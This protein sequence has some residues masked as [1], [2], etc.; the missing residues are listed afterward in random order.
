MAEDAFENLEKNKTSVGGG[1][2]YA[3]WWNTEN[4]NVEDG[5]QLIGIVV[6]KHAYTDPGGD[7]HPVG[8]VRSVGRGSLDAGTE[9]STPTRTSVEPFVE[10]TEVGD[11]VF[12]EYGGQV[13]ANSGR[14]MH[15]YEA[16]KMPQS[17]WEQTNQ[18]DEILEVW[19]ASPHFSGEFETN[20]SDDSDDMSEAQNFAV[21]VLKM[22]GGE[23][24]REEFD[25]Y[26]NDIKDYDVDTDVL[27][28]ETDGVETDGDDVVKN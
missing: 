2:D 23:I 26:V 9:A 5:D 24:S 22:N 13:K 20:V 7:D 8:T 15:I 4:F 28:E 21:D 27:I 10:D 17:E 6:E 25:E 1:S 11:L 18:A 3:P 19:E 14:D 16:S 12:I